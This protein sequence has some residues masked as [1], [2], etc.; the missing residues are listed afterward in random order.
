MRAL[1]SAIVCLHVI[2]A[3]L[4]LGPLTGVAIATTGHSSE[5]FPWDHLTRL[6]RIAG[7]SLVGMLV[8]G[9]GLIA[10]T[11]GALGDTGWMRVSFALFLFL[12]FLHGLAMRQLRRGRSATP[13]S[14]PANSLSRILWTMCAVVAAI[15]Y[16][17]EAKP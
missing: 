13:P 3:I 16:L 5:L 11:H 1:Y 6:M 4:G 10:M 8:T 12:G 15:A 2:T 14:T 9:A 7:W 17:M